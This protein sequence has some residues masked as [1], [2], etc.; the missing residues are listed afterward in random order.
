MAKE[1]FFQAILKFILGAVAVG[2]FLFLPAGTFHYWNAWLLMGILFLPMFAAGIVMMLKNPELLKKRLNVK[3][4]QEEQRD[5]I[6]LSG[7]M[8]FAGFVAAGFNFRCGW[9]LMPDWISWTGAVVFLFSYL[10]YAEVLR[11]NA[12]LSRTVEVQEGQKV[13]DTG[14]YGIVR[15]PMYSVTIVLFLSIP[16]VLGSIISFVIFLAYPFI[17]VK[18]IRNEEVVLEKGLDGYIEYEKKVTYRI[19]PFI[20]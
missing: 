12:Y 10:F 6:K 7:L 20:W 9:L 8:F 15:H 11:E 14:L 13:I 18:R 5:V 2:I 17:I 3:E 16:L 19:I 4:R 1:L